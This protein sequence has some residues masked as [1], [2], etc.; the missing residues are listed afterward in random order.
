MAKKRV[1]IITLIVVVGI[2]AVYFSFFYSKS[3]GDMSCFNSGLSTCRRVTFFH[4]L[5]DGSWIYKVKGKSGEQC[6][7]NVEL[8][9]LKQGGVELLSLEGKEMACHL[10]FGVVASPQ[11]NLENCHGELKEEMQDVIITR[12]H[13]YIVD[14]LGEISAELEKVV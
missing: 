10:P 7:V 9:K 11:E 8:V 13:N 5:Q 6:K 1:V 2:L 3:C 12:L 4:D 14:N